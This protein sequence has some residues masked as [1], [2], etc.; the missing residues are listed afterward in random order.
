MLS[1][2]CSEQCR[3]SQGRCEARRNICTCC[4]CLEGY[5]TYAALAVQASLEE[6]WLSTSA[7]KDNTLGGRNRRYLKHAAIRKWIEGSWR[8]WVGTD[9]TRSQPGRGLRILRLSRCYAEAAAM[10]GRRF[11]PCNIRQQ[12]R[13]PWR[14]GSEGSMRLTSAQLAKPWEGMDWRAPT[15]RVWCGGRYCLH[16]CSGRFVVLDCKLDVAA[17][18]P[19][20]RA[21]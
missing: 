20:D 6:Q 10:G 5:G 1:Y 16:G 21:D 15:A 17:H 8:H 7:G 11:L 9:C 14:G 3:E 2:L 13:F 19:D 4:T 18:L 12:A